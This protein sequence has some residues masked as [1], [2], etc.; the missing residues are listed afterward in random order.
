MVTPATAAFFA[1]CV[2][3]NTL[4]HTAD[5]KTTPSCGGASGLSAGDTDGVT[6]YE[7]TGFA[8]RAAAAAGSAAGF[9][10]FFVLRLRLRFLLSVASSES[11]IVPDMMTE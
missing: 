6:S 3:S 7:A 8:G 9:G 4:S 10:L 2:T 11:N 5:T 1:S